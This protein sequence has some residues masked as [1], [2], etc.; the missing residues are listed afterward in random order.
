MHTRCFIALAVLAA[1][2]AVAGAQVFAIR[3]VAAGN[4]LITFP[5]VT[6]GSA[7]IIG[8]T[9]VA[10]PL[11][12]LDHIGGQL[13]A[14]GEST[15][16]APGSGGLYTLNAST[17]AA[18][19]VGGSSL[20]GYVVRDLAFSPHDGNLYALAIIP[21]NNSN[22]A[23]M[24]TID[25]LTG[26]TTSQRD[27][28]GSVNIQLTALAAVGDGSFFAIDNVQDALWR[29]TLNSLNRF[30]AVRVGT[31]LG[32]NGLTA[33]QGFYIDWAGS[34]QAILAGNGTATFQDLR[35]VN[36]TSGTGSAIGT[37]PFGVNRRILDLTIVPAPGAGA[38]LGI[39]AAA[40]LRRRRAE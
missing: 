32:G 8:A 31:A 20:G 13:Y 11:S 36:L 30:D 10:V 27:V 3:Q 39:A 22:F 34:G 1:A 28:F 6:P 35:S 40:V 37:L 26:L 24:L 7:T 19:Y 25:P 15:T 21:G 17:G 4:E 5:A 16:I 12:G 2:P 33:D 38:L 9:G 29:L 14:Y 23:Q 18:T